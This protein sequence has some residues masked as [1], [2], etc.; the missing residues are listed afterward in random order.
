MTDSKEYWI[1]EFE[2]AVED[3]LE[4]LKVRIGKDV[5]AASLF[6]LATKTCRDWGIPKD[7]AIRAVKAIYSGGKSE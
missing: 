4:L 1:A 5:S 7:M 6:F 2:A 3:S